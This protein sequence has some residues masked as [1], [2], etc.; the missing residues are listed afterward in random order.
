M[1]QILDREYTRDTISTGTKF[2]DGKPWAWTVLVGF[3]GSMINIF[4]DRIRESGCADEIIALLY[5]GK[6][7]DPLKNWRSIRDK[8]AAQLVRNRGLGGAV[9]SGTWGVTKYTPFGFLDVENGEERYREA[10]GRHLMAWLC[11]ENTD[12][13]NGANHLDC[14]IWN[15]LAEIAHA[16]RGNDGR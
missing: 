2:D 1:A 12:E 11:G 8:M 14:W 15:I 3:G 16:E 5:C 6:L 7:E 13:E 10:G 9:V 4:D